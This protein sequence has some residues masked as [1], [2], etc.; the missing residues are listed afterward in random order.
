MSEN[1]KLPQDELAPIF[2]RGGPQVYLRKDAAAAWNTMALLSLTRKDLSSPAV[3][4]PNSAYRTYAVQVEFKRIYG[5]NAATPGESNHG[6]GLAC[7]VPDDVQA[8]IRAIGRQFG[9]AKEWSDAAWEPW[10]FKWNSQIWDH[11]DP[12][13]DR[14]SPILRIDSGGPGQHEWV[15]KLQSLLKDQGATNL[16]VDGNFGTATK[17]LVQDF[18]DRKNLGSTGV[19]DKRIWKALKEA[20]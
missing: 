13:P 11:P 2:N 20:P 3:K 16:K 14:T 18:Q 10:H 7:D 5:S 15:R 12:G 9:W 8:L 19:V 6:W 4:G 1:G 17:R